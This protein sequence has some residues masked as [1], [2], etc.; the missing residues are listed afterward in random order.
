MKYFGAKWKYTHEKYIVLQKLALSIHTRNFTQNTNTHMQTQ[1]VCKE[2]E[3]D[4]LCGPEFVEVDG[5]MG[6][7]YMRGAEEARNTWLLA[8]RFFGKNG[9]YNLSPSLAKHTLSLIT[10]LYYFFLFFC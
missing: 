7:E 8:I 4:I 10:L 1:K 2:R 3:R 9:K 6:R 5:W